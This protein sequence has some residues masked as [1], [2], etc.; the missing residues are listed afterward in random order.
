MNGNKQASDEAL[1]NQNNPYYIDTT[2]DSGHLFA[3]HPDVVAAP[4]FGPCL[5]FGGQT[6]R[7]TGNSSENAGAIALES[8]LNFETKAGKRVLATFEIINVGTTAVY[9]DWRRLAD[10]NP[11]QV[12]A[13][14][15]Q[16]FY[17]DTRSSVIMP[18]DLLKLHIVFKSLKGILFRIIFF[19]P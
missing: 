10:R 8:R 16:R 13:H 12:N 1:L 4:V 15:V 2:S 7:W 5:V 14:K 11:F 3:A 6:A 19:Y 17:F 18:G 9:Y